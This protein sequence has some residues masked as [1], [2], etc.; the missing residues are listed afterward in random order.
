MSKTNQGTFDPAARSAQ[1]LQLSGESARKLM[2]LQMDMA[3]NLFAENID[4][5]LALARTT[6][7]QEAMALRMRLAQ[8]GSQALLKHAQTMVDEALAAR[9]RLLALSVDASAAGEPPAASAIGHDALQT[10]MASARAAVDAMQRAA[11][12]ASE[13]VQ[14]GLRGAAPAA[15]AGAARRKG[16]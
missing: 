10:M 7:P 3:Q 5:A 1:L 11:Q 4:A 13:R 16:A 14:T 12:Q 9:D 6:D 15:K 2:Q 8:E